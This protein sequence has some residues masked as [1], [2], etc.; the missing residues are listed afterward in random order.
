MGFSY[1]GVGMSYDDAKSFASHL[2]QNEK[3]VLSTQDSV[4]VLRTTL[5]PNRVK[6]Y[7]ACI[8]ANNPV[9][10]VVQEETAYDQVKFP[11]YISWN[12]QYPTDKN[13]TDVIVTVTNGTVN[14]KQ[15]W[16]GK[17]VKQGDSDA[18]NIV[19]DN[20][21][22]DPLYITAKANNV[23]ADVIY[24][25]PIRRFD[26]SHDVEY[27]PYYDPKVPKNSAPD[28]RIC[29]SVNCGEDYYTFDICVV[30]S[31]NGVLL[32]STTSFLVTERAGDPARAKWSRQDGGNSMKSCIKLENSSGGQPSYNLIGGYANAIELVT[33]KRDEE[34]VTALG[35]DRNSLSKYKRIWPQ[36]TVGGAGH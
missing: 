17:V 15:K 35:Y 36:Y 5:D 20:N 14:G 18:L 31:P 16:Q 29:R 28:A 22:K 1:D 26:V 11:V 30:P 33:T 4:S 6:A 23:Q 10:I 25:P 12:P 7:I 13:D 27:N 3:Y 9:A 34:D 32:P 21:A 8:H 24:F 19:R 2:A